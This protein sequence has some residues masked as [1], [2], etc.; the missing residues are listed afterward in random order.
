MLSPE[1]IA[2]ELGAG[3]VWLRTRLLT[4][5]V[6]A[7]ALALNASAAVLAAALLAGLAALVW[8][9]AREPSLRPVIV[10]RLATVAAFAALIWLT[11]PWTWSGGGPALS[12]TGLALATLTSLRVAAIGCAGIALLA[13]L[14]G[15][16]LGDGLAAL[17]APRRLVRLLQ[18]T[19]RYVALLGDSH[20]RL[21]RAMRARGFRPRTDLRTLNV[22][23]GQVAL[24]LAHAVLRARRI[25]V[26][27]R[28]RGGSVD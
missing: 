28:A 7:L 10:R 14:S 16:D 9:A 27:M 11:L 13:G 8:R 12:A 25:S 18:L 23:A 3:P 15:P 17:G 5:V 6:L 26:A 2:G 20:R 21:D 24:I 22:L 4:M 1:R 19:V